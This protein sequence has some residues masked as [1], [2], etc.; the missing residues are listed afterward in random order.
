MTSIKYTEIFSLFLGEVTDFKLLGLDISD[1][2]ALMSEYL[3]KAIRDP[4]VR[5]IFSSVDADDKIQTLT[6][7]LKDSSTDDEDFVK[8]VV[9]ESMV[10]SWLKPRV[11]SLSNTEQF[12]GGKE[13]KFY[14]QANHIA[15]L[16]A[17]LK[18][19]KASV[20]KM[21]GDRGYL[22]N[23]YLGDLTSES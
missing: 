22:V 1:A 2:Y 6:F 17:M 23:S 15:Q 18:D 20:R 19:K 21:I 11:Y 13:Q 4:Y 12:F 14:A 5:N 10:I 3:Q 8:T 7:E 16:S 9:S